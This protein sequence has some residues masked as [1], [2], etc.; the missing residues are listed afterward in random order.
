MV[1]EFV[2]VGGYGGDSGEPPKYTGWY[3]D[4]FPDREHGAERDVRLVAD[5]FTLTNADEV[6]YLGVEKIALGAFVVDVGGEPRMM[7]GPVTKPYEAVSPISKRLD[8]A[9]AREA[10]KRAPWLGYVAPE[11]KGPAFDARMIDCKKDTRVVVT[12]PKP[13][14]A[15]TVEVLDH[16]G[17]PLA[18]AVTRDV[19]R[20]SQ[21]F[22]FAIDGAAEGFHVHV[23]SPKHDRVS[24]PSAYA[25]ADELASKRR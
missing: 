15:V 18:D 11:E 24:A 4:L 6:R 21:V 10:P 23:A 3:F 5:Y 2:P 12:S 14:G 8:D 9:A 19:G 22:A 20:G 7:V 1:S 25:G 16:H 17:D 13:L